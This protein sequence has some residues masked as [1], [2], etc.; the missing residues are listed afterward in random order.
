MLA[1][2]EHPRAVLLF[3]PL[4]C[5]GLPGTGV[6]PTDNAEAQRHYQLAKSAGV[7]DVAFT[8]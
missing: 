8:V 5:T 1:H 7:T 4:T 3:D 6:A 2:N